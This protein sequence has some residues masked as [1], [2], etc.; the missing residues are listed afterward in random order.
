[1][2]H[3][4]EGDKAPQF[5]F[6]D[7]QGDQ[8]S[9]AQFKGSKVILY[10]YPRDNTP[11]CTAE[12]CNLRDNYQD[13]KDLGYEVVGVSADSEKSHGKFRDKF[14]LPFYLISDTDKKVLEDYGV[15]G[16]K[17]MMGRTYMGIHRLTFVI[18]ENGLI[19][20]IFTKVNTKAHTQQILDEMQNK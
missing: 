6:I 15:W 2:T 18:D 17:K 11:G 7:H 5:E 4:K 13:L 12:A 14:D 3:L 10:F 20:K 16:E 9:L 8:K 1:M 19:K